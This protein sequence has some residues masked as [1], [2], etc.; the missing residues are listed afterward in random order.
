[1]AKFGEIYA[2]YFKAAGV[3]GLG[4]YLKNDS[5]RLIVKIWVWASIWVILPQV[6]IAHLYTAMFTNIPLATKFLSI[7]LGLDQLQTTIKSHYILNNIERFR[8]IMLDLDSFHCVNHLG[9]EVTKASLESTCRFIKWLRSAYNFSCY[10]TFIAWTMFP[11]VSSPKALFF[12]ENV[13]T[14]MKVLPPEYPFATN[15]SPMAQVVYC[16]ESLSTFVILTFFAST[17][18]ILVTDILLIC[19]LFRVLNKSVRIDNMRDPMSLRLFAID[20]QKL[21][22]ISTEVRNLLSPVLALQ[23]IVSLITISLATYEITMVN[24]SLTSGGFDHVVLMTRKSSYT[25][26]IFIELLLYCWLSTEL[27]LSCSSIR[28]G[29]Y[30]GEW[31]LKGATGYKDMIMISMRALKPV[32][33][34]AMN[35]A[36][37]HLGTSVEVLRMAYTYYTYLKRLH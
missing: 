17:N 15:Y 26:I 14:M 30:N 1:M 22:K 10:F 5:P 31:V 23:L 8:S 36:H 28:D 3:S 34:N 33:L 11:V 19:Q 29:V 16:I 2:H 25:F 7:S 32:R 13:A 6:T 18:L 9:P 24:Q 27:E 4:A 35:I 37:L 21:L 20:H 12:G